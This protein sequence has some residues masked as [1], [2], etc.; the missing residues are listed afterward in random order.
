MDNNIPPGFCQ[1][2]CGQRTSIIKYDIP[3]KGYKAGDCRKFVRFHQIKKPKTE[4][5][6]VVC[7]VK[8]LPLK[9]SRQDTQITCSAKC[10]NAHNSMKTAEKRAEQLRGRGEGK[11]YPKLNGRHKHR[12]IM[13]QKLGRPLKPGEIVHHK[14]E[15][16]QNAS[17]D[18]LELL[19]SQSQHAS[20]HKKEK[21]KC[22]VEGCERK[23][24]AKGFCYMHYAR[25]LRNGT[26]DLRKVGS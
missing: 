13:E 20:I 18:N 24:G 23:H 2:G 7:G 26:T 21:C 12:V 8:F 19:K 22:N 25:F 16:K 4:K 1:C 11:T 15:D 6:C 9:P 5:I 3:E 10:R 14:D 17:P